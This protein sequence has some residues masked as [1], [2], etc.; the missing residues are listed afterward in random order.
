MENSI[1]RGF[2]VKSLSSSI[3][4]DR[5]T[6]FIGRED[7]CHW[8]QR[9][10]NWSEPPTQVLAVT[11]IGGVGKSTLLTQ[12]LM[13]ARNAGVATV[14]IDGRTCHRTPQGFLETL[15]PQ[16]H[17]WRQ[18]FDAANGPLPLI[19]AIDNYE[20]IHVLESWLREVFL[21]E[22]P[23][24]NVLLMVASRSNLMAHWQL[25]PGWVDRVSVWPLESF[26]ATEVE[27]FLARYHWPPAEVAR[28]RRLSLGHPLSLAVIADSWRRANPDDGQTV[29]RL[30]DTLCADLLREVTDPALQPMVD[31]LSLMMEANLDILQRVL[32][33]RISPNK[34]RALKSLSFVKSSGYGVSL[35]DIAS[36]YL[37]DDLRTRDPLTFEQLRQQAVSVLLTDWDSASPVQ[38]GR[39]AQQLIW[40]CRD[41]LNRATHYAD[42]SYKTSDLEVTEYRR[43]DYPFVRRF[44]TAWDR[45]SFPDPLSLLDRLTDRFPE[46]IRVTRVRESGRPLA[47]FAS[48]LLYQDTLDLLAHYHPVLVEKLL[49]L[50]LGIKPGAINDASASFNVLTGIDKDDAVYTPDQILGVVARDQF[51]F[52]AS[53][54]GL[55]LLTNPAI[56]EFLSTIGYQRIPFPVSGDPS[57]EEELLLLDLRGR[58]FGQWI[59]RI[60]AGPIPHNGHPATTLEDLRYFLSHWRGDRA[61]AESR[62]A[63]LHRRDWRELKE[64]IETLIDEETPPLTARD[65]TVLR[66]AFLDPRGSVWQAAENLHVSR[67]TF[68]RY[69]DHAIRRLLAAL[70]SFGEGP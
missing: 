19:I 65:G 67:A 21:A 43:D 14:W 22:L 36:Q 27:D 64:T 48:L 51:S 32:Q 37:F 7:R 2:A 8:L 60:L 69:E 45:Q 58:H 41:V 53:I 38:Q 55:L 15:P 16:Y 52:Q 46:S 18:A 47:A 11:G 50:D 61:L 23:D 29:I 31:V 56:K 33:Q 6:Q 57:L 1:V 70:T 12:C 66:L 17:Q 9:W 35:H 30:R 54:L 10:L 59:R 44:V 13:I 39:L 42:L 5:L 3:S 24:T 68:Y 34:Y 62:L 40:L 49:A 63:T 25:E 20:D 28:A 4:D 26:T